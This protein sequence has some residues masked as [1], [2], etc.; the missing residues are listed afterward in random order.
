MITES[1]ADSFGE[2]EKRLSDFKKF[3]VVDNASSDSFRKFLK[4]ELCEKIYKEK[5]SLF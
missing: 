1:F 4:E 2:N 3:I 5:E